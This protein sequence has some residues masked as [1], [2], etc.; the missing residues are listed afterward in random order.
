MDKLAEKIDINKIDDSVLE[1][2]KLGTTIQT[3]TLIIL[4]FCLCSSGIFIFMQKS[5]DM[6]TEATITEKPECSYNTVT[7]NKGNVKREINCILK[8]KYNV[9]NVE[10][11]TIININEDIYKMN[12]KIKINYK[13]ENPKII[14]YK[15]LNFQF[16]GGIILGI[17]CLCILSTILHVYLS[18][19]SDWYK[20]LQCI[21]MVV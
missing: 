9:D 13:K 6:E 17:A 15:P 21:N 7:D 11:N 10:Y 4:V 14:E 2:G 5:Y 3:I 8:I 1:C 18:I 16:V 19:K 20:R 12:D